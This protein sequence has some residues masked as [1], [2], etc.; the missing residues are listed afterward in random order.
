MSLL[1]KATVPARVEDVTTLPT[2]SAYHLGRIVKIRTRGT[3]K[4]YT[5][6]RNSIGDYEWV[7]I[8]IS[9]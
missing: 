5:C 9:T 2:P 8:T 6:V 7:Q 1:I 4:V 3:S